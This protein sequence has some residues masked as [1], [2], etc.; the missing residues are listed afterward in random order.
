M[1]NWGKSLLFHCQNEYIQFY[2]CNCP[3]CIQVLLTCVYVFAR[4][5]YTLINYCNF[6]LW[7]SSGALSAGLEWLRWKKP[8]L[9]RPYKVLS[10][11]IIF[12]PQ[13]SPTCLFVRRRLNP[14]QTSPAIH[15]IHTISPYP[16]TVVL[17]SL[18]SHF[19]EY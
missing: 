12:C 13:M 9:H 19:S 14:R 3:P 5:V 11:K 2:D 15:S 4:D 6:F 16:L 1:L 7:S 18:K 10:L 17:S 8:D